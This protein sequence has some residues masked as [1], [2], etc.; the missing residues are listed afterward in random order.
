MKEQELC[1]NDKN[2]FN[3]VH[4]RFNYKKPVNLQVDKVANPNV[5]L[6]LQLP[7]LSQPVP[8]ELL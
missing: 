8:P 5:G 1:Q 2:L 7:P 4:F 6:A 3:C